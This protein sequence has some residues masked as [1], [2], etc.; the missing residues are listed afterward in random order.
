MSYINSITVPE[1]QKLL[2]NT[3]TNLLIIIK[4]GA[5]WCKPCT[6]IKSTCEYWKTQF[7]ANILYVDIDIDDNMDL[8]LAF[9]SKKMVRG[10]PCI[11]AFDCLKPR[12]QW[13]ISDDS[14]EGGDV[15]S[16]NKFFQRVLKL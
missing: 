6:L 4:F 3:P 12:D 16:V 13:Y 10:V 15:E 5:T 7:P 2:L 9:K 8:Y 14:V 1:F 11:F